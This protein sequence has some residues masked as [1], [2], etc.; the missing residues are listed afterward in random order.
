EMTTRQIRRLLDAMADAGCL[1]V[2]LTGGEPLLRPDFEEIYLYAKKKGFIVS[3]FTNAT[4]VTPRIADLLEEWP[5]FVVEISL[6]GAGEHVYEKVTGAP[7][8]HGRCLEGIEMLRRRGVAVELKTLVTKDNRD[9]LMAIQRFARERGLRHRFDAYINPR[10]DGSLDPCRLRLT[11]EEVVALDLAHPARCAA[12]K[13]MYKDAWG[14]EAGSDRLYACAADRWSFF[15]GA[16]GRMQI[17]LMLRQPSFDVLDGS[18]LE[19]WR[20]LAR[21]VQGLKPVNREHACYRCAMSALCCH[22]PAWA[23]LE[24]NDPESAV[25]F[26]CRTAQLRYRIF[27]DKGF[28][29]KGGGEDAHHDKKDVQQA[30]LV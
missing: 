6:Y 13:Q 5:P 14:I 23:Q 29:V 17:C 18:F 1:W 21:T 15:V 22:C 9:E 12:W 3:L 20:Q 28:I 25:D 10:L 19:A 26:V 11:P 27:Q 16:E 4:L 2:L 30:G 8:A 24:N 7:G